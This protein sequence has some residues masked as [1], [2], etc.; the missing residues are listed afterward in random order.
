MKTININLEE[1]LKNALTTND[2]A[3]LKEHESEFDIDCRFKYDD[4][5]TLL[6]YAISDPGSEVYKYL[7][8]RKADV[9]ATNDE[10][11]TI[12]HSIV[13]SGIP[14][15]LDTLLKYR[16]ETLTLLNARTNE[17]VTPLLLAAMLEDYP[18]SKQL[19]MLGAD[20]NLTDNT[21][22]APIHPAC[23][24]GNLDLVKLL[25]QH[26]ADLHIKTDKGNLPLALAI[27]AGHDHVAK[28]LLAYTSVFSN[29]PVH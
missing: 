25:V 22:N 8:H 28:Y 21:N 12:F 15:R 17:G 27:N 3:W 4:N 1:A 16:P 26:G 5:D 7:L 13:Y 2:V 23:F 18:M 29:T 24:M 9:F 14:D 10:G 6:L 20:V 19:V 11:E